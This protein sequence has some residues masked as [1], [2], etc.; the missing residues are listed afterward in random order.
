MLIPPLKISKIAKWAYKDVRFVA[1]VL[2]NEA[3]NPIYWP[4]ASWLDALSDAKKIDKNFQAYNETSLMEFVEPFLI[5]LE[6]RNTR[7]SKGSAFHHFLELFCHILEDLIEPG[8]HQKGINGS[9]I[10][11]RLRDFGCLVANKK[12]KTKNWTLCFYPKPPNE[13][14]YGFASWLIVYPKDREL[15]IM[16]GKDL[17][18]E[19]NL[20]TGKAVE[21]LEKIFLHEL[22]HARLDLEFYLAELAKPQATQFIRSTPVHETH[23]WLY[24]HIIRA[25][26][27]STRSRLCRILQDCDNEWK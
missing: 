6:E 12:L 21:R 27:S 11:Q 16:Y 9:H 23:A 4:K 13:N 2:F 10:T 22:G 24:A 8:H 20:K 7:V 17:I 15:H 14:L 19:S 5:W 25:F 3:D 1:E 26:I 18:F